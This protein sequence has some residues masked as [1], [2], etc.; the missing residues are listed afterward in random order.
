MA[1]LKSQLIRRHRLTIVLAIMLAAVVLLY[2]F[3]AKLTSPIDSYSACVEA[4]YP[5][6]ESEPPVCREGIHNFKG[7]PRPEPAPTL[8]TGIENISFDILVDGDTHATAPSHEQRLITTPAQWR[9]YWDQT[10]SGLS[11]IPPLLPVD[12][13][14]S[15]VVGVSLG[16]MTTSGYGLKITGVTST[17]T[18]TI[19]SITESTP[20]I[21]CAVAQQ[22]SN[23]YLIIRTP[24]LKTPVSFRIS[25]VKRRC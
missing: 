7:T 17:A 15:D 18:G 2:I 8:A 12:F 22:I 4:G 24:K 16:Q 13:S 10:H 5:V 19:V 21:T 23:R 3:R 20:T 9:A 6:T 11:S 25:P 14:A 1:N